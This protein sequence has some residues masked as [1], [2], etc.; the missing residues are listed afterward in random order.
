MNMIMMIMMMMF[1]NIK[2]V[3]LIRSVLKEKGISTLFL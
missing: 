3:V 2:L 1:H